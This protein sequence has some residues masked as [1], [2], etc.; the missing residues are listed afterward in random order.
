MLHLTITH[1]K[2]ALAQSIE[3][4][5]IATPLWRANMLDTLLRRRHQRDGTLKIAQTATLN[6]KAAIVIVV[7]ESGFASPHGECAACIQPSV[8]YR[9]YV[10]VCIRDKASGIFPVVGKQ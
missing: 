2:R 9:S 10:Q 1:N 4:E 7:T 6:C 3:R 8:E 5:G